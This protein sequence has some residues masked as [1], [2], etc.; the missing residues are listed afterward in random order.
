MNPLYQM[1]NG[2]TGTKPNVQGL[3]KQFNQLRQ[4]FSGDP[5]QQVQQLL[6]SGKVSQEQYNQAVQTAQA[7]QQI[8]K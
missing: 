1:M 6:N 8:L 2:A 4:T 7:L 3:L 5:R